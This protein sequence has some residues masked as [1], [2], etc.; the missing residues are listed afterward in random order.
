MKPENLYYTAFGQYPDRIEALP[1]G[2]SDRKY[3]RMSAEGRLTVIATVGNDKAEDSAFIA[4]SRQFSTRGVRVPEIYAV[5]PDEMVYLQSDLG[6]ISLFSMLGTSE[7]ERLVA[8]TLR[9]LPLMQAISPDEVGKLSG[10]PDFSR[11]L[12]MWDVNYFKYCFLRQTGVLYSENALEDDFERLANDVMEASALLEGFMYRD[13]QSRNVMIYEGKPW[14]IDYQGGRRGPCVYDAVSF[15]WQA[16]AGFT[17]EFREKM[18]DE[19]FDAWSKLRSYDEQRVRDSVPLFVLLRTLQVLGAYGFRGII[20][21]RAHFLSSI[22]QGIDNLVSAAEPLKNRYPEIWKVAAALAANNPFNDTEDKDRL[23]VTVYSF[24]YKKGYPADWSGNGGG[25]M[26][27]CRALHNPGRY[28]RYKKLTGRDSD[29]IEFLGEYPEVEIFVNHATELVLPA[30]ERYSCRGFTR[31]QIG[32]GCTG[33]QHRSVYCA[34]RI[35]R[36]I[37]EKYPEVK[38]KL[39]HREQDIEEIVKSDKQL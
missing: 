2:G 13:C 19:Y 39:I 33:G 3:Y 32:F 35:A 38:V 34:E 9:S 5:S 1:Q 14:W 18:L 36:K 10:Q 30:V 17:P 20:Q 8:E 7:G 27:D 24:S 37:A 6:D 21:K 26:F 11:R 22:N 23:V 25:F 31:L 16:R 29:V 12:V 15:L 4:L 28:D